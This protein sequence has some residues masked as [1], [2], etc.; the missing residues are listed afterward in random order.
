[1]RILNKITIFCALWITPALSQVL[2]LPSGTQVA[3][4]EV[5]VDQI[6]DESWLRF[7]FVAPTIDKDHELAPSYA[8]LENDFP[9]L[10]VTFAL[11]YAED[12]A[13]TA[14]KVAI[15]IADR[16]VEFGS[17]DPEATQYFEVFR[18]EDADCIWEGL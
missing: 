4:H 8:D 18:P 9:H 13:L 11:P 14:D 12:Y 17:T 7:R 10:C 3:L 2:D 6:G 16:V 15:S 1:M 5:L